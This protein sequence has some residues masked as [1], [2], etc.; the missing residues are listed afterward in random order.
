MTD[1]HPP[2]PKRR[3]YQYSLR[4]LLLLVLVAAVPCSWLAVRMQRAKRQREAIIKTADMVLYDY[5]MD[6]NGI[7]LQVAEPP[8]PSWLRR[9]LGD[10][11]FKEAVVVGLKSDVGDAELEYVERLTKLELRRKGIA[12]DII[13]QV[14]GVIDDDESAYRAALRKARSLPPLDHQSFRHRLGGYLKRR[15][16]GYEVINH[17]VERIWQEQGHRSG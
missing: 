12:D 10:D 8:A 1:S 2:K 5:Q 15:G 6:E 3:W 13:D 17:T 4:T 7:I 9:L 14:A 16:F 11:F